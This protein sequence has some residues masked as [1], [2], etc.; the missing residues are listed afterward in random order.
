MTKGLFCLCKS[1]MDISIKLRLFH[2]NE[3]Y[4]H[5]HLRHFAAFFVVVCAVYDLVFYTVFFMI[6]QDKV[7]LFML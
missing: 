4:R 5:I 1:H 6:I 2:I 7:F 3:Y